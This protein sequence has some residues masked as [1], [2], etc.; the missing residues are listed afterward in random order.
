M[1]DVAMGTLCLVLLLGSGCGGSSP[2]D[3]FTRESI[4][5]QT[6]MLSILES[7][8]DDKTADDAIPKLEK[9]AVKLGET[10]KK[11]MDLKLSDDEGKKVAEK[12]QKELKEL[13]EKIKGAM[14]NAI[15]VAPSNA[16]KLGPAML[17]K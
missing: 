9:A 15:K 14:A 12:H 17:P 16:P 8:K 11:F 10:R 3:N 5:I 13:G 4:G 2:A 7:I 1:K 6:E